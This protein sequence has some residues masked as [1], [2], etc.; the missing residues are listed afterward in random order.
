MMP[1]S[2]PRGSHLMFVEHQI[3]CHS[4]AGQNHEDQQVFSFL[5]VHVF[6]LPETV[7]PE[8]DGLDADARREHIALLLLC[9]K[10]ESPKVTSPFCFLYIEKKKH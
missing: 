4:G 8:C 3:A 1:A 2:S 9:Q 7:P 5:P 10:N 6:Q